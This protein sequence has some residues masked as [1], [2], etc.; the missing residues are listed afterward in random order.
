MENSELSLFKQAVQLTE[1]NFIAIKP[2][3]ELFEIDYKNQAERIKNDFLMSQLV[4]KNTL[5]GADGKQYSMISLPK[6]GFLRWVYTLNAN[7]IADKHRQNFIRFVTLLHDYLFGEN[8]PSELAKQKQAILY[9]LK[10]DIETKE[11]DLYEAKK[12]I[13][14]LKS[15]IKALN[16]EFW[17]VFNSDPNQLKMSF[18]KLN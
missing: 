17:E 8:N 12:G 1:E 10:L 16:Q 18:K 4:G 3:C 15:E 2:C 7:N 6:S 14:L 5:T 9:Q 11:T 13:Q